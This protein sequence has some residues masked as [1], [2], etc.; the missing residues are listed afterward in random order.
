MHYVE[1]EKNLKEIPK[2]TETYDPSVTI[3]YDLS[4]EER[5]ELETEL[6]SLAVKQYG[7]DGPGLYGLW[8]PYDSPYA[9]ISRTYE[10]EYFPEANEVDLSVEQ[11][12]EFYLVIDT[13]DGKHRAAHSATI[14]GVTEFKRENEL[15][16]DMVVIDDLVE[17]GNFSHRQ[18]YQYYIDKGVDVTK[19]IGVETNFRIGDKTPALN[20]VRV[21]DLA[22]LAMMHRLLQR[23]PEMFTAGAF[24]SINIDSI[25]SFKNFGLQYEPLMGRTD[26]VT[27]EEASGRKFEP[28]FIPYNQANFDLFKSMESLLL[29]EVKI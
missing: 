14:T 23:N 10:N 5:G 6:A 17:M 27:K 12:S 22:Y 11:N 3:R 15:P 28:V 2:M 1:Q 7:P 19:C 13:R 29:P 9:N 20:G 8:V 18:F 24:A 4:P 26:F 25:I 16:T 21:V